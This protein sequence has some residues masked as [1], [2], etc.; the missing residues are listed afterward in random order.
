[1]EPQSP[2]D[3]PASLIPAP[4]IHRKGTNLL[5]L[6]GAFK[7]LKALGLLFLSIVCL[8]WVNHDL[9]ESV[10]RWRDQFHLI[11]PANHHLELIL[12]RLFEVT[13]KQWE[14]LAAILFAYS[15]VFAIE[16]IGLILRKGWAEWMTVITTGGLLPFELYELHHP[17]HLL[18]KCAALVINIL[19]LV[20]LIVRVKREHKAASPPAAIQTKA[21]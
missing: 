15:V 3:S 13:S 16:G 8:H 11:A 20:Y 10:K 14:L 5:R 17:V 21:T 7:L 4:D 19:I 1:M 9:E 18:G 6:I 12:D 2:L